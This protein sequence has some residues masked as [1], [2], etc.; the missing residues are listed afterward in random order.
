MDIDILESTLS[1]DF[2]DVV[3]ALYSEEEA[4]YKNVMESADKLLSRTENS[5]KLLNT[6]RKMSPLEFYNYLRRFAKITVWTER[7]CMNV[8]SM[9]HGIDF[10][11]TDVIKTSMTKE[12]IATEGH[13]HDFSWWDE[14]IGINYKILYTSKFNLD[15]DKIYTPND[16]FRLISE[17]KIVLVGEKERSLDDD[18]EFEKEQY[19]E[20]E[21]AYDTEKSSILHEFLSKDG[22]YFDYTLRYIKKQVNK[23]KLKELYDK[24]L[25][26][27]NLEFERVYNPGDEFKGVDEAS[28]TCAKQFKLKGYNKR[29]YNLNHE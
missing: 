18:P 21:L 17:K 10:I 27:T 24:Q 26:L 14:E 16:I 25:E 19:K 13:G 20:F 5:K 29:L 7:D 6:T 28:R 23:N 2:D 12:I 8:L 11:G 4:D 15:T 3:D 22:K 1:D 9:V